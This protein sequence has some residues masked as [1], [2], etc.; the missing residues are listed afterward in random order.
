MALP[1]KPRV[2]PARPVPVQQALVPQVDS[3]DPLAFLRQPSA[4]KEDLERYAQEVRDT[5]S[6]PGLRGIQTRAGLLAI[7][8]E[9]VPDNKLH[10]IIVSH[11]R[12][13]QYYVGQYDEENPTTPV[14]FAHYEGKTLEG[15]YAH[16]ASSQKQNPHEFLSPEDE[17][18]IVIMSPCGTCPQFVWGSG[19]GRAKA[20]REVRKL[21]VI[22]W[23]GLS[24]DTIGSTTARSLK[25]PTTSVAGWATYVNALAEL[26]RPPFSVITELSTVPDAKTVFRMTFKPVAAVPDELIPYIT[27]MVDPLKEALMTPYS[28]SAVVEQ[29]PEEQQAEQAIA[30]KVV[31]RV[32]PVRK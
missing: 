26:G 32:M 3:A 18:Q 11:I 27:E 28:P 1:P 20:C 9:P 7:D 13:N 14:C 10:I 29:T 15:V 30:A 25:I 17:S 12:E 23:D 4:F 31:P 24:V 8:D 21:A 5:E 6:Q 19:R 2:V 16:E 22:A